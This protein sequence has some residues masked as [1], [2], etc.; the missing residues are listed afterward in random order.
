MMRRILY[1]SPPPLFFFKKART[2]GH[3]TFNFNSYFYFNFIFFIFILFLL[4]FFL[5]VFISFF[6][7]FIFL[8]RL[9]CSQVASIFYFFYLF[10]LFYIV[11]NVIVML[12]FYVSNWPLS[13]LGLRVAKY[14]QAVVVPLWTFGVFNVYR[15]LLLNVASVCVGVCVCVAKRFLL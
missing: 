1:S 12:C 8:K 5:I 2:Q 13:F 10:L 9:I 14:R 3:V 6:P 7:F 4:F 15:S 11:G